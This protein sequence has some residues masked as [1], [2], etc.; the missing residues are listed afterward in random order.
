[1]ILL[2]ISAYSQYV[3]LGL[4]SGTKWKAENES[5]R[6]D[7][8]DALNYYYDNL[9]SVSQF[10]E[11][12]DNCTWIWKGDGYKVIGK[13]GNSIFLPADGFRQSTGELKRV[14]E[15]G[16]YWSW[17]PYELKSDSNN[18]GCLTFDISGKYIFYYRG[19]AQRSIRLV[20]SY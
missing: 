7:I 1:M 19:T 20:K 6:Y 16:C 10:Q 2:S 18:Y 8:I 15:S 12:I 5:G 3:D 4:P 9:P 13:N 11:L 17:E 14:G